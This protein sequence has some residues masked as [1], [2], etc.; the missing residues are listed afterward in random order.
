M[1]Y[2]PELPGVD[3]DEVSAPDQLELDFASDNE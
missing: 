2:Q 3:W 1:E